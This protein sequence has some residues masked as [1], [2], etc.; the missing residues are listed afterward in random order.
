MRSA[1]LLTATLWLWP[2]GAGSLE[3]SI[4]NAY[5]V[6]GIASGVI[7]FRT[8]NLLLTIVLGMA[9]FLLWRWFW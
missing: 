8:R 4:T 5:L 9:L 2:Q 1:I 7:A 6:A 3:I